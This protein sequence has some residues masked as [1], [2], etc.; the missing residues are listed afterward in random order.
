MYLNLAV[1]EYGRVRL[2][3]ERI[4]VLEQGIKKREKD[5]HAQHSKIREINSL[6]ASN[7]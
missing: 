1:C 3:H 6:I 5:V 2:D 4:V 7:K